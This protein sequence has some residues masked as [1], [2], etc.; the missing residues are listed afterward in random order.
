MGSV[1]SGALLAAAIALSLIQWVLTYARLRLPVWPA[2]LYPVT[3]LGFLAIAIA[4]APFAVAVRRRGS[5]KGRAV[6]RPP[7]RWI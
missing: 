5:W 3:M 4:I 2:F 1:S 7:T 6:A